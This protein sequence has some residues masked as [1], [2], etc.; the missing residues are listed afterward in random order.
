MESLQLPKQPG[1]IQRGRG[2]TRIYVKGVSVVLYDVTHP[3]GR[4]G[5]AQKPVREIGGSYLVAVWVS[6]LCTIV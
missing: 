6:L 5:G 3:T 1:K 2:E 4:R